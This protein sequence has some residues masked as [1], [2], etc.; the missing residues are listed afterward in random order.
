MLLEEGFKDFLVQFLIFKSGHVAFQPGHGGLKFLDNLLE[1]RDGLLVE[2]LDGGLIGGDTL[3]QGVQG[4]L[5][6]GFQGVG[7]GQRS[8]QVGIHLLFQV[9]DASLHLFQGGGQ[10]LHRFS[11][12]VHGRIHSLLASLKLGIKGFNGHILSTVNLGL[13]FPGLLEGGFKIGHGAC[14][15]FPV[16]GNGGLDFFL[17]GAYVIGI[18]G[19]GGHQGALGALEGLAQGRIGPCKFCIVFLE[20]GIQSRQAGIHFALVGQ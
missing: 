16:L 4:S 6:G 11:Q 10:L 2:L 13:V 12:G 8:G 3:F 7:V 9:L 17:V 14:H 5:H 18:L 1:F 19:N 20:P 15:Q